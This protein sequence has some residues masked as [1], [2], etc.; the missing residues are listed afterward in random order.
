MAATT[1]RLQRDAHLSMLQHFVNRLHHA[2]YAL[3]D[4]CVEHPSAFHI[5][6]KFQWYGH[7]FRQI[8]LYHVTSTAAATLFWRNLHWWQSQHM[9]PY[10]HRH[11][12]PSRTR[13]RRWDTAFVNAWAIFKAT[14]FDEQ[15]FYTD[16]QQK[17][18]FDALL[19]KEAWN[20]FTTEVKTR[21]IQG[22]F[23]PNVKILS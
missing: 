23:W 13:L 2:K 9:L 10:R 20:M 16:M 8:I 19:L 4:A 15:P 11:V 17:S 12:L 6:M 1:I 18:I 7:L 3:R 22:E 21:L 14:S 5:R